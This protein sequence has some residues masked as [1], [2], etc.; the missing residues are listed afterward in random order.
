V[1]V[2]HDTRR[3]PTLRLTIEGDQVSE[4]DVVVRGGTVVDGTGAEARTADVAM[5]DG[6]VAEVGQVSGRGEQEVDADGALVLP[7]FVDVHTHYDGQVTW[8]TEVTPSSHLGVTT[9][10]MG[11]CG[12]GFAPVRPADH[13]RL[14]DLMEGVEEIPG[15]A[16]HEGIDWVWESFPEYLDAIDARPHDIDVAAQVPHGALRL[17]VMGERGADREVA[18][19]DEVAEMGR[20]VAEAVQAGALGFTTSRTFN[21]KTASGEATPTMTASEDE[22]V[23]IARAMGE[24]GAGVLQL[25]SDFVDGDQERERLLEMVRASG[26]PLSFTLPTTDLAPDFGQQL[27]AWAEAAR[28]E[29]LDVHGQVAPRGIGV[30]LGLQATLHPFIANPVYREIADRPLAER[31]A[32]LRDPSFRERVLS[33]TGEQPRDTIQAFLSNSFE[34]IYVLG[35]PPDYEPRPETSLAARAEREGRRPEELAYDLLLED[36]GRALL[37]LPFAGYTRGG[38]DETYD[39]LRNEAVLPGLGDGGAHVGSI[40][41]SSF[42]AFLLTHWV[43]GRTRGPKLPLP[44]VVQRQCRDTAAAVGLRDRGVLA[45]GYRGDLNVVD[46]EALAL[47]PPEIVHDLPAGSGRLIQ[48]AEGFLATF[49]AGQQIVDHDAATG[50]LPGRLVRGGQEAPA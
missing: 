22:L 1:G 12:V 37:Y 46:L 11:N 33:T 32:A 8:A 40:C 5:R 18:S 29:G 45:P 49:V 47:R 15:A 50:A 36:D 35:D 24:T 28:A 34:R 42:P 14:I 39:L 20:L 6:L 43:Q 10:V 23:G 41:D 19:S 17:Y 31:V 48:R 16:L 3:G 44:W 13:D 7:G 4:F 2:A 26:R 30:M 25:I 9:V 38:L 27:L 21:H